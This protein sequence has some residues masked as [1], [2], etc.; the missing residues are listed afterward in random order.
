M[1][2]IGRLAC[3]DGGARP[4]GVVHRDHL[5]GIQVVG[6]EPEL[7]A[8]KSERAASDVSA[9]ADAGVFAERDHHP[10]R[11]KSARKASPTLTPASIA[12]ARRSAS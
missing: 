4:S 7:A 2:G 3:P 10:Q 11:S 5:D 6:R 9:R 8:D 1:V 12:I